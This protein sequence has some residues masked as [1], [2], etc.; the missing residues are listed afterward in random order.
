M[1]CFSARYDMLLFRY[2]RFRRC[3]CHAY[4]YDFRANT[5]EVYNI[6]FFAAADAFFDDAIFFCHA[7]S[8]RQR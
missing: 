8:C 5:T 6:H 2:L 7:A 1:P 4:A 3:R